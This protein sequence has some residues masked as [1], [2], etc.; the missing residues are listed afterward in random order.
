MDYRLMELL[1]PKLSALVSWCMHALMESLSVNLSKC[2]GVLKCL[3]RN[4]VR[5]KNDASFID[6]LVSKTYAYLT[7]VH[8][9]L[10]ILIVLL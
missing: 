1:K 5:S 3:T 8:L 6:Y 9:S 10:R 4:G 2:W 7:R